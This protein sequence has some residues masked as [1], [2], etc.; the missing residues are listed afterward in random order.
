[1]NCKEKR[2]YITKTCPICDKEFQTPKHRS[3]RCCSVACRGKYAQK[4]VFVKCAW[5]DKEFPRTKSRATKSKSGL[6]F[7]TRKCKDSAQ[8]LGGLSDIQPDHYG[9]ASKRHSSSYRHLFNDLK[10]SRCGYHEFPESVD[11]HHLDKNWKN[12]TLQNLVLLCSC[13][14]RALHLGLWKMGN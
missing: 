10:C 14:H 12:N 11:V 6:N 5:C 4:Q 8:K 9:T 3:F 7:C 2:R 13:C 1:M